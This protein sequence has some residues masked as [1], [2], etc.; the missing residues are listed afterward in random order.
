MLKY[1]TDMSWSSD[2]V[3]PVMVAMWGVA[4]DGVLTFLEVPRSEWLITQLD[5]WQ[6]KP[7]FSAAQ[8]EQSCSAAL[9]CGA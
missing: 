7:N 3:S 4:L 5:P 9:A 1:T 6:M 8:D 2:Q